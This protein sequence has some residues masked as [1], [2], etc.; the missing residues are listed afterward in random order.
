LLSSQV[1]RWRRVEA[2]GA[3]VAQARVVEVTAGDPRPETAKETVRQTATATTREAVMA[4]GRELADRA[5]SR[6]ALVEARR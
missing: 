3:V 2:A 1:L 6:P 4:S 5:A